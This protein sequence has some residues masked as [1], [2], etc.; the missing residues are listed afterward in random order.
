M[1]PTLAAFR[2]ALTAQ[3]VTV[4]AAGK[5]PASPSYPYLVTFAS[6]PT[7]AD[8]SHAATSAAKQ[9]RIA[10]MYVATS[11]DSGLWLAEKAEAALL[12]QRLTI[13]GL[14]CSRIKRQPGPPFRRDPDAEGVVVATDVW[15]FVTTAA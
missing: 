4:Y 7:P 15:S 3:G 1:R 2:A 13:A 8:Y 12:D 14:S 11:E 10:T 6:T 5:V 9:W